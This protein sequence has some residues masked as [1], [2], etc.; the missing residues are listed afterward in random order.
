MSGEF[1]EYEEI[2]KIWGIIYGLAKEGKLGV[3]E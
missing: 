3:F 2:E 1:L